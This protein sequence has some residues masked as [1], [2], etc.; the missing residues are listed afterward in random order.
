MEFGEEKD[1]LSLQS[2]IHAEEKLGCFV[3]V[4]WL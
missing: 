1:E 4:V 3:L 2:H